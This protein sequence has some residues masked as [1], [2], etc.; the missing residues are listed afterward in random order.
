MARAI[1]N[2][3]KSKSIAVITKGYGHGNTEKSA[4][5]SALRQAGICDFNLIPLTSI[6]PFDCYIYHVDLRNLL[7]TNACLDVYGVCLNGIIS[8]YVG[9]GKASAGLAMSVNDYCPFIIEAHAQN[10]AKCYDML[11]TGASEMLENRL[12]SWPF[13]LKKHEIEEEK[14]K[15]KYFVVSAGSRKH[16]FT[17]CV[18]A[19]LFIQNKQLLN[20]IRNAEEKDRKFVCATPSKQDG[21]N[22][23]INL[24]K[25]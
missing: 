12:S 7:Y 18:S 15:T 9:K 3:D 11:Q 6:L 2:E 21:R 8:I 17:A 14:K 22:K 16:K 1:K 10:V 24:L 19:L 23:I 20:L 13:F 4:L 5:D 25:R